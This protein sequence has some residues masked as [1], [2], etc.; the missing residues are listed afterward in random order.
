MKIFLDSNVLIDW[1]LN[2][3]T[4]FPDKATEIMKECEMRSI[5]GYISP[6]T[7]YLAAFILEKSGLKPNDL[8]DRMKELLSLVTIANQG[9]RTFSQVVDFSLSDLEDAFQLA[10]ALEIPG[11]SIFVTA[12]VRDYPRKM[13][14][15][16]VVHT[17]DFHL[18]R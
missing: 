14:G 16:K 6:G 1:L 3:P 17:K 9:T 4:G 12:N 11:C 2:R 8:K 5:Q 10:A 15:I 18:P 13:E 7:M